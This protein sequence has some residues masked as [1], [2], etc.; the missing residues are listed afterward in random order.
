[1]L[2]KFHLGLST[3][4]LLYSIH[5][6]FVV[7]LD[8]QTF[9]YPSNCV[10]ILFEWHVDACVTCFPY[11]CVSASFV[12]SVCTQADCSINQSTFVEA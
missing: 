4:D 5:A 11:R 7:I 9:V 2:T 10:D 8:P 12:S 1:M 3:F 6:S